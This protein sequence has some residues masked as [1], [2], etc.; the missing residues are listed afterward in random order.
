MGGRRSL[1]MM[2]RSLLGGGVTVEL[3]SY[4]RG[5]GSCL[6]NQSKNILPRRKGKYK[7]RRR[8]ELG[9]FKVST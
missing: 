8:K 4:Y 9:N 7:D 3:G 1:D 6:K 5:E 2:E